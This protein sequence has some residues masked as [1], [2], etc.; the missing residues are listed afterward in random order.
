MTCWDFAFTIRQGD[1]LLELA[2]DGF[3]MLASKR[4]LKLKTEQ[5]RIGYL[6]QQALL[7]PHLTARQ[8]L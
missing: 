8:N 6:P 3:I 1:F 7:F 5:R 2:C 4:G